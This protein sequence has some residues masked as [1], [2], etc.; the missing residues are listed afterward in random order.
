MRPSHDFNSDRI[1]KWRTF[2]SSRLGNTQTKANAQAVL[3]VSK[4]VLSFNIIV[5]I[6]RDWS[7]RTG[8]AAPVHFNACHQCIS[9]H[10]TEQNIP[11]SNKSPL[12][13]MLEYK[14]SEQDIYSNALKKG[15]GETAK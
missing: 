2:L 5:S 11:V 4:S 9:V 14:N 7:Q 12:A 6:L 13:E 8:G 10:V 15:K 1:T 3:R